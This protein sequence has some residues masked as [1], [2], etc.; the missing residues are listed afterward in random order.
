M[1]GA[2]A[3]N[4]HEGSRSEYLAQY[5][6]SSWGTAVA[7]PHQEDHG[8]DLLCALTERSGQLAWAR[9]VYTVQVKSGLSVWE[10][11]GEESVRWLIEHPLPLFLS[12]VDKVSRR[13]RIYQTAPR[14]WIW[15]VGALPSRVALIPGEEDKGR[16]AQWAGNYEL[17]LSAP[18]LDFTVDSTNDPAFRE[19]IVQILDFWIRVDGLNLTRI[20]SGLRRFS[21]PQFYKPNEM[22]L[23]A[24]ETHWLTKATEE[25]VQQSLHYIQEAVHWLG[26]QLYRKGDI[27]G[28]VKA[29]ILL[30]HINPNGMFVELWHCLYRL[31]QQLRDDGKQKWKP[32]EGIH[33]LG[34]IVDELTANAASANELP[35]EHAATKDQAGRITTMISIGTLL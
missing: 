24:W 31:N 16:A 22:I 32:F 25:Q 19:K 33:K 15:A 7:I 23:S 34:A 8:L 20:R 26:S 29:A 18:I 30:D 2:V 10:F 21:M 12:V 6:F 3:A 14:F 11:N 13:V 4:F 9:S 27:N 1:P 17:S 35:A 28:A 5:V